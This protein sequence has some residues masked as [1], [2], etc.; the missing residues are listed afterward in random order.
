MKKLESSTYALKK[1]NLLPL[2]DKRKV[3]EAVY[4][5]KG[6]HGKL[7]FLY[8]PSTNS[9]NH[10]Y[11]FDQQSKKYWQLPITKQKDTKT[12]HYIGPLTSGIQYLYASKIL[13]TPLPL[14]RITRNTCNK[15]SKCNLQTTSPMPPSD[16]NL[17]WLSVVSIFYIYYCFYYF[18]SHLSRNL[19]ATNLKVGP[20]FR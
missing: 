5:H 8:A 20:R 7:P 1:A 12:P 19:L 17:T 4:I 11:V 15:P 13:K 16:S 10:H 2:E 3:H 18:F 14:K 6:L 9:S